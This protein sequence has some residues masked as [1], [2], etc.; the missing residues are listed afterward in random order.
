MLS[1]KHFG[2]CM[3]AGVYG[4]TLT[5]SCN[6]LAHASACT[7]GCMVTHGVGVQQTLH[8]RRRRTEYAAVARHA[9]VDTMDALL[10]SLL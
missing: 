8:A 9:V 3:H 2:C 1:A 7:Q 4:C 6:T 5:C 10:T